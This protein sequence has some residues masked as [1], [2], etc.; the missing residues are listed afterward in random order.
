MPRWKWCWKKRGPGRPCNPLF[1]HS[2]PRVKEFIP[3]PFLNRNPIDLSYPEFEVI[4]LVD[5]EGLTQEEA[6][7]K[8]NTSR[9]TIWRLLESAR[10]KIAQALVESRPLIIEPKG[11]IEKV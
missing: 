6:A 1:I 8:M 7:E 11:K 9:G 3:R 5:L 4:R 10:K 2:T